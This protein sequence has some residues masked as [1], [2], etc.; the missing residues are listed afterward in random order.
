[1]IQ[2]S[3]QNLFQNFRQRQFEFKLEKTQGENLVQNECVHPSQQ[4]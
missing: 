2:V 3:F 4:Q 1:M